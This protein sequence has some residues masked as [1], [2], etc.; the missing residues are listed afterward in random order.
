M[1]KALSNL[2]R[3]LGAHDPVAE[4]PGDRDLNLLSATLMAEV[5]AADGMS[6]S[7]EI[8]ALNRILHRDFGLGAEECAQVIRQAT[9]KVEDATSLFEFT[10]KVNRHFDHRQKFDLIRRLWDIAYADAEI[11]KLEEATIRKVA[12]LIHVRHSDFIRAKQM[13]RPE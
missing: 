2:F 10:D 12:E 7:A 3:D 8:A 13:A 5:M 4:T 1:I 6:D 11:D 9:R